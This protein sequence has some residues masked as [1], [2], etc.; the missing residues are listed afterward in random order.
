M[1]RDDMQTKLITLGTPTALADSYCV[2]I[3]I[4]QFRILQKR[5][6]THSQRQ[7]DYTKT[8]M[9]TGQK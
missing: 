7:E 4:I 9:E 1:G 2:N 5:R 3:Y 6:Q 8:Q